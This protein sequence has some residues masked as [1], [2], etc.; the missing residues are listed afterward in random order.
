VDILFAEKT[1]MTKKLVLV[2][3]AKS[4]VGNAIADSIHKFVSPE[5]YPC[6]LCDLTHG[7]FWEKKQ[8]SEFIHWLHIPIELYHKD[9][10]PSKFSHVPVPPC[11]LVIDWENI[12]WSLSGSDWN[13]I[14]SLDWLMRT[15]QW[16]I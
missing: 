2:Y 4:G 11:I 13:E 5:T 16:H 15:M 7:Y 9:E 14:D 6:Q 8:R 12:I 1:Q 3:N 10:I